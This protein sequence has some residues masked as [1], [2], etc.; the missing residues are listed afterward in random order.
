MMVQVQAYSIPS[1]SQWQ[2]KLAAAKLAYP[3][4][5]TFN[6]Y[7]EGGVAKAWTCMGYS[8]Q[9]AWNMF[10]S[11]WYTSGGGW[12]KSYSLEPLYAGDVLRING[13]NHTIF[14]TRVDGNTVYYTDSNHGGN[15]LIYWNQ[16][17]TKAQLSSLL[18][19]KWH[20]NGNT[21]SGNG[22]VT[23]PTYAIISTNKSS[24]NVNETV[25]FAL[26]SDG[27]AN[28]NVVWIYYPDGTSKYYSDKGTSFST[29]FSQAGNYQALVEA[30]NGV[31]SKKSSK[32]SFS[33]VKPSAPTYATIKTD[34]STYNTGETV[35]FAL[36]SDGTANKNVVW[37]YYPDGTSK[38]YSDKG[39][40]FSTSFSQAGNYQALVEAWNGV[41]S[42]KSSQI[43]FRVLDSKPIA[44]PN[45]FVDIDES[46]SYYD[47]VLWAY[48]ADPQI[49]NG[50]DATHFGPNQTVTRGQ[51]VAFLWRAMGC[52]EP[53]NTYN[54]FK[55]VPTS[56]YYYKPVLWAVE[57]GITKGTSTTAFSPNATL[58]TQHIITFLYRTK[59]PGE[60]G[61]NGEAKSWAADVND[62]PFG[63]DIT[64]DNNTPCPR[65]NVVQFLQK[66]Q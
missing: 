46:D 62:K 22:T 43:S 5:G 23:A 11:T 55:D 54:P 50:I 36:S 4:G 39:T 1:E 34:K 16:S 12:S 9:M 48:Y 59:N 10:G 42:M 53:S 45:P 26:S 57:N 58:S 32:I 18:T 30:W 66:A 56:Q 31:G 13:D 64:V 29:S 60:D 35:N 25:N 52:P 17:Y 19:Y 41:G 40:S 15:H 51:C 7:Y 65:A 27:D 3:E 49:T 28:K 6:T 37:I 38:Y 20:I 2:T 8:A 24:F 33:V 14:I 61:W 63:V 47:A 21:L 44:Q